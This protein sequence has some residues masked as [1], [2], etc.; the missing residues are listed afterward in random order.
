MDGSLR[1][2][3]KRYEQKISAHNGPVKGIAISDDGNTLCTIGSTGSGKRSYA[4]NNVMTFDIR[5]VG[6]PPVV[7]QFMAGG[8]GF[9]SFLKGE[10]RTNKRG[11][12]GE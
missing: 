8:P 12:G 1:S 5:M 9:L 11:G 3:K 2:Q 4:D 6:R 7:T 10:V